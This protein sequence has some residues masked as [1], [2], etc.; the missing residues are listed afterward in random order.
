MGILD[1]E[2]VTKDSPT[3][4]GFQHTTLTCIFVP[5]F[6]LVLSLTWPN[7]FGFYFSTSLQDALSAGVS[8][9]LGALCSALLLFRVFHKSHDKNVLNA[10][11]IWLIAIGALVLVYFFVEQGGSTHY[12]QTASDNLIESLPVFVVMVASFYLTT[13]VY[14]KISSN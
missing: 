6:G 9:V 7:L 13:R 8:T 5:V 1:K 12:G 11:V 10:S 14:F 2:I 4:V 3:W